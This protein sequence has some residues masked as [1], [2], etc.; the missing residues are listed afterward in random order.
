[1]DVI[2]GRMERKRTRG[3]RR[4]SM[5]DELMESTYG[6]MKRRGEDRV[7]WRSWTPWTCLTT[8]HSR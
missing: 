3:R 2:E 8:E 6:A 1:M 4:L 7:G 5:I